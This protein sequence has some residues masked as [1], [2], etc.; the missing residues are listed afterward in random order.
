[1][2]NAFFAGQLR[3]M[4]AKFRAD[5]GENVVIR[6]LLYCAERDIAALAQSKGFPIIPCNLCGS[7]P[8]LQRRRIKEMLTTLEREHPHIKHS[9][10]A[11]IGNV[12]YTHLLDRRILERLDA[13][14][15]ITSD[16]L[17]IPEDSQLVELR[18]D[19]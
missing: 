17:E 15:V 16:D 9:L 8:N 1:M 14:E 5:D 18:S 13:S 2:L 19:G 12:R 7:Q 6:P 11:A 3:A 10:L 4:P